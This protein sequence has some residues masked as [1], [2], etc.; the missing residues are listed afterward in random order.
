MS[1][2]YSDYCS[3]PPSLLPLLD[4]IHRP[5]SPFSFMPFHFVLFGSVTIWFYRD[6]CVHI[7]LE[8]LLEPGELSSRHTTET[9]AATPPESISSQEFSLDGRPLWW[10]SPPWSVT[11]CWEVQ[12]SELN[13]ARAAIR[14]NCNGCRAW[15]T[16]F[17]SPSS[18]MFP[19][20]L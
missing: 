14:A 8:L 9:I 1:I 3:P 15:E 17:Y 5:L 13:T 7:G 12:C 10:Q 2:T 16:V 4:T 6:I 19:E 11:N 20:P 18:M